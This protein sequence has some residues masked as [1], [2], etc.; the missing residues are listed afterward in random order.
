LVQQHQG[1]FFIAIDVQLV[2]LLLLFDLQE[3]NVAQRCGKAYQHC[4]NGDKN[5]C[6]VSNK[7]LKHGSSG[8]LQKQRYG[9]QVNRK[10]I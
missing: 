4:Y 8:C 7:L 2:F 3:I 6:S 9:M 5:I 10:R 1:F